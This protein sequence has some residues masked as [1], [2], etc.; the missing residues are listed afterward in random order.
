[1]TVEMFEEGAVSHHLHF[2]NTSVA[3]A[4]CTIKPRIEKNAYDAKMRDQ[5]GKK[6]RQCGADDFCQP[7]TGA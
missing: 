2:N 4:F 5:A 6:S 3:D 1:M 7:E